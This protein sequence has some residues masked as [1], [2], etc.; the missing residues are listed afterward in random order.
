MIYGFGS[1]RHGQIGKHLS[2][3]Q[4]SLNLPAAVQGFDDRKIISMHANGDHS[5]ALSGMSVL[6]KCNSAYVFP[7]DFLSY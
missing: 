3:G 6:I 5:A 1:G 4:R 2:G 7:L